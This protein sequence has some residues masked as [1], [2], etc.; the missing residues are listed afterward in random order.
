MKKHSYHLDEMPLSIEEIEEKAKKKEKSIAFGGGKGSK[1]SGKS[2]K[3]KRGL[4]PIWFLLFVMVALIVVIAYLIKSGI[5]FDTLPDRRSGDGNGTGSPTPEPTVTLGAL[6]SWENPILEA[7][8][9]TAL[10]PK[11]NVDTSVLPE[12]HTLQSD[13]YSGSAVLDLF[14]REYNILFRDPVS[15]QKIPGVLTYR[16]NHFRNAASYGFAS[17]DKKKIEQIWEK[18][19]GGLQ[20]SRWS[21]RWTGTGWTGQPL[22]VKWPED[23]K[24]MMNLYP[25]KK[26]KKDLVEV[27]YATMDGN[28]YFLDLDDG[29]DTRSPIN[30]RAPIKGTPALDPRGYPLLYVG[31]GDY[32][33]PNSG[34]NEIGMRIF[35]L[36]DHSLLAFID[37]EDAMS[38]RSG[39]GA[40]DSSPLIDPDTDTLIWASENG[41]LY[42]ALLNTRFD[43]ENKV[44]SISPDFANLRYNTP[45][46]SLQ[47]IE[48]SPAIYGNYAYFSD[49][50]GYLSCVNLDTLEHVW[51][52]PLDD[53]T[54]VT[55]V[56]SHEEEG[57]FLYT[58]T[59]VDDQQ[60]IS[61]N[62][63]GDAH[64]YKMDAI[65]GKMIW[66][67]KVP[68]WTKNDETDPGN[69]V[70]GG[71]LGA[72]IVGKNRINNL[73][74]FSFCMTNGIYSGNTLA[75][76][77]KE[78]GQLV[79]KYSSPYYGWSSPV[80]IY[81]E[82]G[83]GYILFIDSNSDVYLLNGSNGIEIAKSKIT[84]KGDIGGVVESSPAVYG[85]TVVI[86]TR[87]GI[88][89]GM[90]IS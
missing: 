80:D 74:V 63:L 24:Q 19:I 9:F 7:S 37:G 72:P 17:V 68:C 29:K 35:S 22:I 15:Y 76:F 54:D 88:I 67:N 62:Y 55:P 2:R 75:A 36:I 66:K 85:D 18:S 14:I 25:G 73:V 40:S 11:K 3:N 84:M 6:Q 5:A 52:K 82:N 20:S 60:P 48:S 86:G 83:N 12:V 23:I 42:T 59:Q 8:R 51:I 28:I 77:D 56:L 87:T 30:I 27:I 50:S 21:F 90:K 61:G 58:G 34:M 57:V 32:G 1:G 89:V 81:D 31:Q 43:R 79:W 33:P 39:W 78:G 71:V 41:V 38:Y 65:T 46:H 26:D 64:V 13:V 47:G 49:N 10:F 45:N 53:D 4:Y 69:D 44:I 16:G 70:N